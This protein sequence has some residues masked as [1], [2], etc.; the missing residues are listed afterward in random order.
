MRIAA[1][2]LFAVG[3]LFVTAGRARALEV[4]DSAPPLKVASWIKGD[5]VNL[6]DGK[7]KNVFVVEFWATWC[8]PCRVSIPHLTKLQKAFKDQNV[9]IIGVSDEPADKVRPFVE[10]QG[11]LMNY[12]VACDAA[13][14]TYNAYMQGFK[15][16]GIPHSFVVDKSGAIV[17]HGH[18]AKLDAILPRV[19]AGKYSAA[20]FKAAEKA[21]ARTQGLMKEYFTLASSGDDEKKCAAIGEE[22]LKTCVDPDQFAMIAAS[23]LRNDKIKHRDLAFA[24][25][26]AEAGNKLAEGQATLPLAVYAMALAEHGKY[27]EAIRHMTTAIAKCEDKRQKAYLE[28]E[29]EGIKQ[30]ADAKGSQ[31]PKSDANTPD[32]KTSPNEKTPA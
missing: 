29:L 27:E 23:I 32:D 24:L 9:V 12:V 13:R 7:G 2:R 22:I 16:G 4:G 17:W 11:A 30:K 21:E 14:A 28:G 31:A 18:P 20:D 6:A 8:A 25:R 5:P 3:T 19:A 26:A 1:L 15:V 10:K